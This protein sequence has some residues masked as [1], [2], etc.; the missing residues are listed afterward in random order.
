MTGGTLTSF[1]LSYF[2]E[3]WRVGTTGDQV[4][5]FDYSLNATSIGVGGFSTDTALDFHSPQINGS[6]VELNGNLAANRHQV[7]GTVTN[8]NWAAGTDLWLR[9]TGHDAAMQDHGLAIDDLQFQAV[10][11]PASLASLLVLSLVFNRR[12]TK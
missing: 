2:G 5:S 3:Q 12:R 7:T 4:L 10:P 9:W 8:I 6:G 11:E 1:S